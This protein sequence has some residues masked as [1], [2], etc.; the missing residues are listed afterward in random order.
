MICEEYRPSRRR[1][2]PFSPFGAFSYSVTIASLYS[3]LNTR[4]E[5]RG[6]GSAVGVVGLGGCSPEGVDTNI[7]IFDPTLRREPRHSHEVSQTILAK[8][9]RLPGGG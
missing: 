8:R 9:V 4:R 7:R 6:A 1:I 2:A 3:V 5:G